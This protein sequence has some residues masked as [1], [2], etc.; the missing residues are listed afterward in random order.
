M[1]RSAATILPIYNRDPNRYKLNERNIKKYING[2]YNGT[3][4]ERDL[5]LDVYN[6]ITDYLKAGLYDGYGMTL[7]EAEGADLRLLTELRENVYMF[8]AAKNYQMTKEISS[9]L[10]DEETGEVRTAKEFN[11]IARETYDNWNDNWGATEY[12]TAVGQ[13]EAASKWNEI[14]KDAEALPNLRYSAIL[15]ANTSDI[16]APL[17]GLVAPVDD[18]IWNSV[19]PLN[20]FNCF[21]KGT[22]VLTKGGWRSIDRVREG[23]LVIGGSGKEQRVDAIHI[24]DFSGKLIQLCIEKNSVAATK[25]HRFL[26]LKGWTCAEHILP[27][28]II[29]QDIQATTFDK[30]VCAVNNLHAI[31]GYLLM[32]IKTKRKSSMVNTL[33][34]NIYLGKKKVRKSLIDKFVAQ[35]FIASARKK[36]FN[37]LLAFCQWLMILPIFFGIGLVGCYRFIIRSFSDFHIMHRI[38]FFHSDASV[39]AAFP[40]GPMGRCLSHVRK[41]LR[42]PLPSIFGA[43]PLRLNS[44]T[45]FAGLHAE[46]LKEAHEG[47]GIDG[48]FGANLPKSRHLDKVNTMEGF[49][50]GEPLNGFNSLLDFIIHGMLHRKFVVVKKVRQVPYCGQI[51]NLSVNNDESYITTV[52]VVHNCRCVLLQEGPDI[53]LTPTG[54][55]DNIVGGVLDDMQDVFKSNPGKTGEIFDKN[56]PY[57]DVPE[58]DK[59]YAKRNFDLPIPDKD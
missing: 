18:P 27:G 28:D 42:R 44:L 50:A 14:E 13:A 51:Y 37:G 12:N 30:T 4:T 6:A 17:D 41:I 39:G 40:N 22:P 7:A 19:A 56:H 16:C 20:H 45:A 24:N 43:Y 48:P 38:R 58:K 9:L 46:F 3:I 57:F 5:S 23:T 10:V 21:P 55:K 32:P 52:G 54:E 15:D 47:S 34:N 35:T 2:I 33:N 1:G 53:K 25:E 11:D 31:A 49:T 8:G 26:T 36:I 29:V 59:A